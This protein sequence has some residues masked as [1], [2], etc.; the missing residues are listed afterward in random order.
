[1]LATGGV[2][3]GVRELQCLVLGESA[4]V[5]RLVERCDAEVGAQR[6]LDHLRVALVEAPQGGLRREGS[7]DEGGTGSASPCQCAGR[8]CLRAGGLCLPAGRLCLPH[9]GGGL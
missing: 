8:L 2:N 1:M 6:V 4:E 7:R 9:V 3:L 5:L